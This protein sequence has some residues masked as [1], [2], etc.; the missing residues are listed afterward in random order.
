LYAPTA[1]FS[2]ALKIQANGGLRDD[3][4][5]L[6]VGSFCRCAWL[7]F[8]LTLS[9]ALIV[10]SLLLFGFNKS[11]GSLDLRPVDKR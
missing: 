7:R 11:A 3:L 6:C 8:W 1:E 5:W 10:A 9:S 2:A 4:A